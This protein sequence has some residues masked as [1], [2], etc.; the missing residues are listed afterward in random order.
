MRTGRRK[1]KK[2]NRP[3]IREVVEFIG[4]E[5]FE[6]KFSAFQLPNNM[7]RHETKIALLVSG[8]RS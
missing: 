6:H 4:K 2:L 5:P 1:L 3:G 8:R 7:Y